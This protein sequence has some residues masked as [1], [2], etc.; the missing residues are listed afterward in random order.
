MVGSAQKIVRRADGDMAGSAGDAAYNAAFS[1]WFLGRER[2]KPPEAKEGDNW[3]DRGV[4]FRR[5]GRIEIFE[6]RGRF[7][8]TAPY[9][10]LGSGKEAALGAMFAGGDPETAVRAAIEHDPHT[11]GGVTVLRAD[12]RSP[13]VRQPK[14]RG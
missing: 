2:G 4:I 14:R 7:D 10:A 5:T 12:K 8:C 13:V 6:P 3:I 1:K 9:Y 11:G